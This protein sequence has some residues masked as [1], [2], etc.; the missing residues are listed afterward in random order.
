MLLT[1]F[2]AFTTIYNGEL[3][4]WTHWS[5]LQPETNIR[6][7]YLWWI[8]LAQFS[9]NGS[10]YDSLFMMNWQ[11]SHKSILAS[12]LL[13]LTTLHNNFYTVY[14]FASK[15]ETEEEKRRLFSVLVSSFACWTINQLISYSEQIDSLNNVKWLKLN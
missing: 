1:T 15:E 4:S 12:Y 14:F 13:I 11:N 3:T 7:I 5:D 2:L 10:T 9:C 6:R 8:D